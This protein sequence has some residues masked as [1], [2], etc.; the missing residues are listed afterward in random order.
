MVIN[1]K[2]YIGKYRNDN[3]MSLLKNNIYISISKSLENFK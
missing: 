3:S 1:I 2:R